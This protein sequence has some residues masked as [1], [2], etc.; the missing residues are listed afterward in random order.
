[1]PIPAWKTQLQEVA[2]GVF[3]S[4]DG[5]KQFRMTESDLSDPRQGLH[6]HFEAIGP[7]LASGLYLTVES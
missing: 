7:L 5:S 6:V 3:R 1:M 2:S 4:A